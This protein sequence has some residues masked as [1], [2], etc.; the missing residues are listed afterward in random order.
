MTTETKRRGNEAAAVMSAAITLGI[1][2][3]RDGDREGCLEILRQ[4]TDDDDL[5]DAMY[6]ADMEEMQDEDGFN[7]DVPRGDADDGAGTEPGK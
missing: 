7:Q 5:I 6:D 4:V 2:M 3:L 1:S